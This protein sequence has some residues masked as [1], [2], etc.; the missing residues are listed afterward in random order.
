VR[1]EAVPVPSFAVAR[2]VAGD[3]GDVD[4]EVPDQQPEHRGRQDIDS[5]RGVDLI[6]DDAKRERTD[7]DDYPHP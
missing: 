4:G 6:E 3:D 7:N 5:L 2:D 1:C